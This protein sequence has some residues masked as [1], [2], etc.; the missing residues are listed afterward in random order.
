MVKATEATRRD[1]DR[2]L[3][4]KLSDALSDIQKRNFI[5]NLLQEMR[6]DGIV[7][8]VGGRRG[9]GAKWELSNLIPK[10]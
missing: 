8:P 2:L 10:P 1:F 5:R 4:E 7:R 6:Q 3:M 9:T